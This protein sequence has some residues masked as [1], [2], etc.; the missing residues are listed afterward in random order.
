MFK[1]NRVRTC[2]FL[3]LDLRNYSSGNSAKGFFTSYI[4]I[5]FNE[6]IGRKKYAWCPEVMD[7]KRKR[8]FRNVKRLKQIFK[9][10]KSGTLKHYFIHE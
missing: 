4:S 1:Y 10:I 8:R 9:T 6:I 3:F 2:I 7:V 5:D